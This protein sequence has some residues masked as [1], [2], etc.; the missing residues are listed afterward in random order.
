MKLKIKNSIRAKIIFPI[1]ILIIFG[2]GLS[3]VITYL[4][5]GKAIKTAIEHNLEN[6]ATA[7]IGQIEDWMRD[8]QLDVASWASQEIYTT[9]L[10]DNFLGKAAR[11]TASETMAGI[12]ES[13]GYFE[14]IVLT[15]KNADVLSAD[16]MEN[17]KLIN[18]KAQAQFEK[19]MAGKTIVSDPEKSEKTGATIITISIPM[20]EKGNVIGVFLARLVI[21]VMSEKLIDPIRPGDTGYAF[22]T[23]SRG[24]IIASQ[25]KSQILKL[26]LSD[27]EFGKEILKH[28]NG[29]SV[30]TYDDIET[31]AVYRTCENLGW[32]LG[33]TVPEKELLTPIV[34]LGRINALMTLMVTA[35]AGI[36]VF[37]VASSI[38]RRM[39]RVIIG[40]RDAAEGEGDLTK[41]IDV[42]ET[43]EVGELAGWFNAFVIKIQG[44]I[45]EVTDNAL[46]LDQSSKELS[47]VASGMKHSAVQAF[48]KAETVASATADVNVHLNSVAAAMEQVSSNMGVV[49][50]SGEEMSH[51]INEIARN[52]S[53]ALSVTQEAVEKT[54]RASSQVNRLGES[55]R[56]IGKVVETITDIS[57]QVNLLALNATIEAA[58][59]GSAGSGFAVVANEIKTLA[60]QTSDAASEIKARVENIQ[61]STG[62]TVVEID[63]ISQTTGRT[64]DMVNSIAGAVEEQTAMTREISRNVTQASTGVAAVSKNV[65]QSSL[66]LDG[67]AGE[68]A[69]VTAAAE[70]LSDSSSHVSA[71]SDQLAG[72]SEQLNKLVNKFKI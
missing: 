39:N 55:A 44:I 8:R 28:R 70:N 32:L 53:G 40:L 72:F 18:F 30:Y 65:A 69:Q 71:K 43:D 26:N 36:L 15:D 56:D 17:A 33:I 41:R 19:T 23:N 25:D 3:S 45:C 47:E 7:V 13:Y 68:I 27:L 14:N 16:N 48:Q 10:K 2:M 22:L 46:L 4:R 54:Q 29:K 61:K 5:S 24:L 35:I 38:T 50:E 57:E 21:D 60:R 59:A 37:F 51:T 58:R 62:A 66:S 20:K 1:M 31:L 63:N 6:T 64:N 52:T 11:K 67:I 12:K 49:A 42:N 34:A 9:A